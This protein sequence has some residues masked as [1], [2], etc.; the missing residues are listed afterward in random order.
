[1]ITGR[2]RSRI[3]ITSSL[4]VALLINGAC[5]NRAE[6]LEQGVGAE[7]R[8]NAK[9]ALTDEIK[10]LKKNRSRNEARLEAKSNEDI[11]QIA[12]LSQLTTLSLSCHGDN[13][14][15]SALS[16]LKKLQKL[17][18]SLLNQKANPQ[19]SLRALSALPSLRSLSVYYSSEYQTSEPSARKITITLPSLPS[20]TSLRLTGFD[21]TYAFDS[22]SQVDNLRLFE[23]NAPLANQTWLGKMSRLK[24]LITGDWFKLNA[25]G[26]AALGLNSALE[27]FYGKVTQAVPVAAWKNL[28]ELY[29]TDAT[30]YSIKQISALK[31]LENL[32]LAVTRCTDHDLNLLGDLTQLK[33]LDFKIPATFADGKMVAAANCNGS[34]LAALAH[35]GKIASLKIDGLPLS[36]SLIEAISHLVSLTS[37]TVADDGNDLSIHQAKMLNKLSRLDELQI[38]W[39]RTNMISALRECSSISGLQSLDL[40]NQKLQDSDLSVL[41]HFPRLST[42][43]LTDNSLTDESI[44]L[45]AELTQLKEL[46]LSGNSV[47]GKNLSALMHLPQLKSLYLNNTRLNDQALKTA[48]LIRNSNLELLDLSQNNITGEGLGALAVLSG[49]KNLGLAHTALSDAGIKNLHSDSLESINIEESDVTE[50]GINTL[51][52][53]PRLKN[54]V[55]FNCAIKHGAK[56][57]GTLAVSQQVGWYAFDFDSK[58]KAPGKATRQTT[59][60]MPEGSTKGNEPDHQ[61]KAEMLRAVGSYAKAIEEYDKAIDE[62]SHP[63]EYVCSFMATDH[64][65]RLF[66]SYDGRGMALTAAGEYRR[67]LNDL[68]RANEIARASAFARAHRGL[69]YSKLGR[70]N[71]ALADLNRA[72]DINPNL[73]EAYR[74]RSALHV[75]MGNSELATLDNNAVKRLSSKPQIVQMMNAMPRP[76]P[77]GL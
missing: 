67:A 36:D 56:L 23:I 3:L 61:Q 42:L 62:I 50:H 8:I 16:A 47:S 11:R 19:N 72:I 29:T 12:K 43:N 2:S 24:C 35:S 54:V 40:S 14:D 53:L 1:M 33:Y 46:Y 70:F 5:C 37:L 77:V 22:A 74:Y 52:L 10:D 60:S 30:P 6:S 17:D 68:N 15:L 59:A 65:R 44:P 66:Q 49:L 76:L 51:S 34:G 18:L 71:E 28:K 26:T 27:Q 63:K 58:M 39:P 25:S 9:R 64:T 45:I 13:I 57:P 69:V 48:G 32:S 55:A 4:L 73:A 7:V 41:N 38:P 75:A 20:V 31:T 21:C